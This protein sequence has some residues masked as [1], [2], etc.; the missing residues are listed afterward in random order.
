[1]KNIKNLLAII[2]QAIA[3]VGIIFGLLFV[4]RFAKAYFLPSNERQGNS[5]VDY[6]GPDYTQV[7]TQLPTSTLVPTQT[8]TPTPIVLEN[9]WYL[10]ADPD[11]EF[12]FAYPSDSVITAG[13]NP[14]DLSININI[15]FKLPHKPYQ[16]MSIRIELNPKQL[17][18]ADFAVQ[19]YEKSAQKQVSAEFV[20]SLK[21]ILIGG[22]PAVQA[23]IPSSNTEIT[24]IVTN[25]D[26][27]LF[28]APVHDMAIS[29]V[30]KETLE[31][32]YQILNTFKFNLSK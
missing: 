17:Q 22:M 10:Y 2:L 13:K 14:F 7:Y 16:G 26:K 24:I 12:T 3:I 32:F 6:P 15:Q 4:F 8:P 31:L 30:E 18:S 5:L 23:I 9:G 28:L 27:V 11:N 1:M 29:M 21:P 19:L 20:N 25:G